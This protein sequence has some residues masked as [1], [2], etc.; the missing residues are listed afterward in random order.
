VDKVSEDTWNR[1]RTVRAKL[2]RK[3]WWYPCSRCVL[4]QRVFF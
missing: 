2:S 1:K 3:L 4:Q